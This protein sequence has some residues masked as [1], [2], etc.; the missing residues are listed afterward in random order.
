[1]ATRGGKRG[2]WNHCGEAPIESRNGPSSIAQT[3]VTWVWSMRHLRQPKRPLGSWRLV[4]SSVS[5]RAGHVHRG[6]W[7][8]LPATP[9]VTCS[10]NRCLERGKHE[11][12][13]LRH[14][15]TPRSRL[16]GRTHR[17]GPESRD[18]P[19]VDEWLCVRPLCRKAVSI[20]MI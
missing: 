19:Y 10:F 7:W 3:R 20:T 1:M 14:N 18:V 5:R 9:A 12:H 16:A 6:P 17:R 15:S 11:S 8:L 13:F 2:G 4:L